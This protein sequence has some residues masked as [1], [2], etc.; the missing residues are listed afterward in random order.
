MDKETVET[1][2]C[3]YIKVD[4]LFITDVKQLKIDY[5]EIKEKIK[6]E[7]LKENNITP[8]KE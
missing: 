8:E 4:K 7:I 1:N 6:N 3:G 5:L 2:T